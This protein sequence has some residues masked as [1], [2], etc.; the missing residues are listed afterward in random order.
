LRILRTSEAAA[1]LN[2]SP[3]TLRAWEERFGYPRPRRSAGGHRMYAFAELVALREALADGLG[4]A[5]A[6]TGARDAVVVDEYTLAAA[7]TGFD[8]DRADEAMERSLAVGSCERAVLKLLLPA[9]E[10]IDRRHGHGS[11]PWAFASRWAEE[12]LA[13]AQRLTGRPN[14]RPG[15]LFAD[16]SC[17]RVDLETVHA[18]VL[19]LFCV[20]AGIPALRLPVQA[21]RSL[22]TATAAFPP[23]IVIL[24]GTQA[25]AEEAMA[26]ARIAG[27]A[28]LA[29]YRRPRMRDARCLELSRLP[30][31]ARDQ[32]AA[33]LAAESTAAPAR[34]RR[35]AL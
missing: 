35:V 18:R 12:W 15:A 2:V 10:H 21:R 28:T 25:P 20:R 6:V 9:L 14:G 22:A 3:N 19:E 11:A 34:L 23:G 26:F 1:Y 7:L 30:P 33:R 5:S 17:N 13:R 32:I 4:A 31:A 27:A 16:C 29:Q 8:Y 24:T